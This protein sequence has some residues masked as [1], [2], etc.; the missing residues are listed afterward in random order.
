MKRIAI[1]VELISKEESHDCGSGDWHC[2][3]LLEDGTMLDPCEIFHD[4]HE[5]DYSTLRCMGEAVE[6]KLA[7]IRRF[8]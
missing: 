6:G 4:G 7:T 8:H 1:E 5:P 2:T 3:A